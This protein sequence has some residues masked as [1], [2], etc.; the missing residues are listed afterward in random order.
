MSPILFWWQSFFLDTWILFQ[1][2]SVCILGQTIITVSI[3]HFSVVWYCLW[4]SRLGQNNFQIPAGRRC[5]VSVSSTGRL[6]MVL[7]K[8]FKHHFYFMTYMPRR[9]QRR[10]GFE[11]SRYI[12]LIFNCCSKVEISQ[13]IIWILMEIYGFCSWWLWILVTKKIGRETREMMRVTISQSVQQI[14]WMEWRFGEL[15]GGW[16]CGW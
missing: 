1:G 13:K 3:I 9:S 8:S 10:P 5:L 16:Q 15:C 14:W 6:R 12:L 4:S 7:I 11:L 2:R